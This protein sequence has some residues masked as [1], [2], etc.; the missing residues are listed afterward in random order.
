MKLNP[1]RR[2]VLRTTGTTAAAL[3][4]ASATAGTA[5]AHSVGQPAYTTT[6]LN[7]REGPGLGYDVIEEADDLTGLQIIDGPQSADGYTWWKFQ[8]NGDDDHYDHYEGWAVEQYTDIADFSYPCH[9]EIISTYYDDRSDGNHRAIDIADDYG[10]PIGAAYPGTV[11]Q[12]NYDPPY[13]CGYYV[14]IDHA[15]G[16]ITR[17][18]HLSDIQCSDGESVSRGEII[19][20]MGNSGCDCVTHLHFRIMRG[21]DDESDSVYWP[22]D[23]NAWVWKDSGIEK[24]FADI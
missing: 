1:T 21:S 3:T 19:G 24:D 12:T 16:Y 15:A 8:V 18:C 20:E 17:Y 4:G 11:R 6:T 10:T 22:M 23:K 9:G 2:Q 5:A 14:E 7:I 13:G